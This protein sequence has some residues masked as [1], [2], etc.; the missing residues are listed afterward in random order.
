M[1]TRSEKPLPELPLRKAFLETIK[2]QPAAE[3]Q[4]RNG[5]TTLIGFIRTRVRFV[6]SYIRITLSSSVPVLSASRA[7]HAGGK[8]RW[9]N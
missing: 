1:P 6:A 7:L 8:P 2:A 3:L 9:K 4:A 5:K